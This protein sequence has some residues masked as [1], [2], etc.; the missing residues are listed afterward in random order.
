[1]ATV[2]KSNSKFY[3]ARYIGPDGRR[4]TRSLKTTDRKKAQELAARLEKEAA[5][6]RES[7]LTPDRA[8]A[9]VNEMLA[10][11]G[12]DGIDTES[13][14][15]FL[16]RWLA[17]KRQTKALRSEVR[18]KSAVDVF[19]ATLGGVAKRPLSA[20]L[21]RHVE[22]FRDALKVKN[23]SPS[24]IR[25]NVKVIS[26]AFAYAVRQGIVSVNPVAAVELDDTEGQTKEP[27][28]DDELDALLQ[29]APTDWKTAV[30]LGACAG[31]R[32]SDA[33]KM[34]WDAVDFTAKT[35]RFKPQK[36]QRKGRELVVPL[37][38]RLL[39]HLLT[40]AG[41]QT[42]GLLCPSL[43]SKSV[44]GKS[45]L[46]MAFGRLMKRAGIDQGSQ[47]TVED[48][49]RSVSRKSFHS[50]RH[51]FNSELLNAGVDERLR[52]SLSGHTTASNSRRYS[53]PKEDT[54]R[55]AVA[56]LPSGQRRK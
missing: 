47:K 2:E 39:D 33:V 15:E 56:K 1:M 11:T 13:T 54:L 7:R 17:G 48:Q 23:L 5:M 32:L 29:E 38:D 45:G 53:H 26:G 35:L 14:L 49:A 8:R 43:A 34:S 20:V 44:A 42:H 24:T 16:E 18:Y 22:A 51:S 37:A 40:I 27:F 6:A 3:R 36:T 55:D 46:S 10:H 21:P 12:Q 50:L 19:L 52:M 31:C 28:S 30:L 9:L 25:L 4:I 41:D